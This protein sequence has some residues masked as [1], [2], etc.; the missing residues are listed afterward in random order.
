VHDSWDRRIHRAAQLAGEGGDVAPLL[1]FYA[2][3]LHAQKQIYEA[4]AG[5]RRLS[6]SPD[7][8]L[9]LIHGPALTV[10]QAVAEYGPPPLATEARTLMASP[11][12][13][14]GDLLCTYWSCPSDRQFFAK[15]IL[16][17]YAQWLGENAITPGGRARTAAE[18][19]C[20]KC[21]GMAQL[22]ILEASNAI[23]AGGS[24]R[25]LL[26]STCLSTWPFPRIT[27]PWCGEDD[28]RKLGYFESPAL[29]C[30]RV[31]ACE[32]CRRYSKSIDLGR[33]G[34]AVPLVD[35]VAGAALDLW[36]REHG[37]EKI[38][39]NLVGL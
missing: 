34:F 28:E 14:I 20:P 29:N 12:A 33:L 19:R 31:D 2:R 25:L 5:A 23:S 35:E 8:D 21:G 7:G 37:Y 13:A 18:N 39:L 3:L 4:L 11:P 38:E 32:A 9:A 22:S 30:Q 24:G 26:C 16:Q 36:A 1:G 10:L 15:A 27:C 6:G 17:P